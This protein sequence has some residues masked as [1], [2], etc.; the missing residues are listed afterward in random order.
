VIIK[1]LTIRILVYGQK[2]NIAAIRKRAVDFLKDEHN[3]VDPAWLVEKSAAD[4]FQEIS[5][6]RWDAEV[7]LKKPGKSAVGIDI[8]LPE[9]NQRMAD[10]WMHEL[11]VAKTCYVFA[12]WLDPKENLNWQL[13]VAEGGRWSESRP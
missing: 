10:E 3:K 9:V 2:A 4:I 1:P 13:L 8:T 6:T 5:D 11:P 12:T 7:P